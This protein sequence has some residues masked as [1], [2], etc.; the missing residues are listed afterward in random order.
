MRRSGGAVRRGEEARSG[1]EVDRLQSLAAKRR[2]AIPSPNPNP[3]R[4]DNR[5]VLR[6]PAV[7]RRETPRR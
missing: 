1:G 6:L 4:T 3:T 2:N 7:A 5:H